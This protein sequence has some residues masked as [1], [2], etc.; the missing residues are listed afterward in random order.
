MGFILILRQTRLGRLRTNGFLY[1][2]NIC[3][4]P[5]CS[6]CGCLEESALHALRDCTWVAATWRALLDRCY[7][8]V[9]FGTFPIAAWIDWNLSKQMKSSGMDDN[10]P[11]DLL[12][13]EAVYVIWGRRNSMMF[14][15]DFRLPPLPEGVVRLY[16]TERRYGPLNETR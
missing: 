8:N 15:L 7:Y 1:G 2:C 9:F 5:S 16:K 10:V 13:R 4:N 6:F 14:E 3:H 12:F 11:W